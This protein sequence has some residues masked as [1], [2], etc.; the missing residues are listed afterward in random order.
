[1][2]Q[3]ALKICSAPGCNTLTTGGRCDK[4]KQAWIKGDYDKDRLRGRALQQR[5]QRWFR[6]HPMCARCYVRPAEELDHVVPLSRGGSDDESNISGL[7]KP[8]HQEKSLKERAE[9]SH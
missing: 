7:C 3:R 1:M 4:H 8:C 9:I 6:L 5:R 2:P